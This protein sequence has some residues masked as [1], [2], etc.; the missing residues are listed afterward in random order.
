MRTQLLGA[1][2]L[3]AVLFPQIGKAQVLDGADP[4]FYAGAFYYPTGPTVFFDPYVM[5]RSGVYEGVP[6]YADVTIEPYS[7]V[8]VPIGG[9]VMRPYER[10]RSGEL[11]GTVGS[12]M[13]SFPL[14]RDV[15]VSSHTDVTGLQYPPSAGVDREVVPEPAT[16]VA[17]GGTV[18]RTGP[19][20]PLAYETIESAPAAP[21]H[22]ESIPR[23]AANRG[24][25]LEYE[26]VQWRAAGAA[27][28]FV[29]E[30]FIKI[31]EYRGFPVYRGRDETTERIYVP[32]VEGGPL[33]RYERP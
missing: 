30:R 17:T 5:I 3:L 14:E 2:V 13:P 24:V 20:K 19:S 11:A 16:A 31:G 18:A 27:V 4:I 10:R 23:P 1:V 25:W 28:S 21:T 15:D 32:A 33:S 9:N 7:F 29:P 6:L 22:I 12:R 26:G 8:Y